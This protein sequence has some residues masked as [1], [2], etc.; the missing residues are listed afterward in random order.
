VGV[1]V[2]QF[3]LNARENLLAYGLQ[4]NKKK[5]STL[6]LM[7]VGPHENFYTQLKRTK[8]QRAA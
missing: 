4:P 3:K 8:S 1:F 2:Y 7:A 5:P 6:V